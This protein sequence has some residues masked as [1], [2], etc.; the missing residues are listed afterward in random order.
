MIPIPDRRA[1]I[2]CSAA[3]GLVAGSAWASLAPSRLIRRADRL[4][5]AAKV[6]GVDVEGL[7]DSA[8]ETT[9]LSPAFAARL[10]IGGGEQ[11]AAHGSGASAMSARLVDHVRIEAAGVEV[12]DATVAIVD[13]GDVS[14]RLTGRPIDVVV[15]REIFDA[16]RLQIDIGHGTIGRIA[17]RDRP[18]GV[19]LPLVDQRGLML[20]PVSIEG[21]APVYAEFDLGNGTG[22][23]LSRRFASRAGLF[24]GRAITSTLGGGLGGAKPRQGLV[25][26]SLSVA[27]RRF[28][29]VH[30]DIDDAP[31]A[32]DANIG[33]SV[34]QHF[35]ITTDFA[36]HKIW[37]EAV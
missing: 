12:R 11:A 8:A 5:V 28:P 6:N 13:L 30:V 35:R 1:V 34:L 32:H 10:G 17:A 36:N 31:D 22:V 21:S 33:V 4:F 14:R 24:N 37:L 15:G 2:L 20:L 23:I 19:E 29:N 7:L 27:G 25:V 3:F 9:L 18:S 26:K 16:A